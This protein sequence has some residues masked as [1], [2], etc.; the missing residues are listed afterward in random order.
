[1]KS[2]ER[3]KYW[4]SLDELEGSAE[5]QAFVQREFPTAA[6]EFPEGISRRRWMQIMGAS[7]ALAS[8]AGCRWQTEKITPFAKRPE[9]RIPG[10]PQQYATSI[11]LAGTIHPLLVTCH[12]GR[13]IK[14]EGNS[15]HPAS[16]GSSD[17]FA[18]AS[19]LDLYDPDR[20]HELRLRQ[21]R[22]T[23]AREWSD[24]ESWGRDHF[25]KLARSKGRG[26]ALLLE[27]TSSPVLKQSLRRLQSR[28]PE[29]E[30]FEFA[31]VS[32]EQRH[33]ASQAVFGE[34]LQTHFDLERARVILCLDEDLLRGHPSASRHAREFSTR[35]SPDG[36]W[37]NRL[38]VVESRL[39]V[40]GSN[41]DHRLPVR[42]SE[43]GTFLVDLERELTRAQQHGN[44][45]TSTYSYR[46]QFLCALAEDL[47]HHG[48]ESAIAVGA[49][50][51]AAVQAK[52]HRLNHQLGNIG[53][54]VHYTCDARG[55]DNAGTLPDLVQR[56]QRKAINTLLV[57]G[58]NP[59][60]TSPLDSGFA[61]A[62]GRVEHSIHLSRYLNETSQL[63]EWHLPETHPFESWGDVRGDDGVYSACQPLMS[64]L[65]GGRSAL[66]VVSWIAQDSRDPQQLIRRSAAQEL[67]A[68]SDKQWRRLLHDGFQIGSE[69]RRILP[70]ITSEVTV[71][72]PQ[73]PTDGLEVVFHPS[74]A[75]YDGVFAN[76]GWLQETPDPLTKL[77]WDNVALIGPGT[78]A[79]LG[80]EHGMVIE[81]AGRARSIRLPAFIM[82]GQADGSIAVALGYGRT[83]A[84][85]V[86]G[87]LERSV[88]PVGTNANRLRSMKAL[89]VENGVR[90]KVTKERHDL[91][92]TQDHHAID[93][94]GL[95]ERG[96][97]VGELVR[98]GTLDEYRQH[99][100]FAQHQVHHPPLESLWEEKS[101]DGHAWGMSIDLNKCIGC[102]ACT[103]ACQA[104]NNVPVVGKDQVLRGREMHWIRMDRY[105]S[106]DEE[107][108]DVTHQPVAC[109]HCENAPCEQVCPVAATVHSDEGL[110]D[111]VYNRCVGTRYCANNCPYKVR[112]FN[113]F[114]YNEQ[115]SEPG[116]ELTQ[117]II[118]PEVTVRSRGVMEKCTYCVQRIQNVKIDAKNDR[119]AILDGEIKT[120]CQQ[121]CPSQAI[122]FGDLN[123]PNSRVAQAH[124]DSRAYGMLAELNVKPRTKY[125]ARITNPHP[126]IT[127]AAASTI[128]R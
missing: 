87:D 105:F 24:F 125:L 27:P 75:V 80:V 51:S 82:P 47:L 3:V 43:I 102:N 63:S 56:I 59:V 23:F 91:A 39:S 67:G 29:C 117:L 93:T 33:L 86:G 8:V 61:E 41:A 109:H 20:S 115:L 12:D 100:D 5:F 30:V 4:R 26:L 46:E 118:N 54:T 9:N 57:L 22:R 127:G 119:R 81:L 71:F 112:R 123:D 60:Y 97:R 101:Y 34:R 19:I 13:P 98:G 79:D 44:R 103:V 128:S 74:D 14:V 37:M 121:A 49:H 10:E 84:G 85:M 1:M 90:V 18:Q 25:A 50:Q 52:V 42:S 69:Y 58:G 88:A 21:N 36:A 120:A 95:E 110:N 78:A 99:P 76:N 106:G 73:R 126:M 11:D 94:V 122:E 6:S 45:D 89:H 113:F 114:D 62:I 48:G 96:T 104:E 77:T 66:Q 116:R 38:F 31:S 55:I 124:A 70:T 15:E 111:M 68:L 17:Q 40:T 72:E 32:N 28:F 107:N 35:R 108:P 7:F 53:K 2:L 92:T 65:L 16:R 64:P 83:A